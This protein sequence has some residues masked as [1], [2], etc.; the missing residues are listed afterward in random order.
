M[1]NIIKQKKK[2]LMGSWEK[3]FATQK[4]YVNTYYYPSPGSIR[5]P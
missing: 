2:P 1:F 5:S 4:R 3:R